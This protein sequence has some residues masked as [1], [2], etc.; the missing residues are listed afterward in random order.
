MSPPDPDTFSQAFASLR[1]SL[2]Y[3]AHSVLHSQDE[4]ED[5]LQDTAYLAWRAVM[6]NPHS[7]EIGSGWRAYV[8]VIAR[9]C[10]LKRLAMRNRYD[11]SLSL[12]A[13]QM[14]DEEVY[15]VADSVGVV[16]A[17]FAQA[18]LNID[19]VRLLGG[20]RREDR[21][22]LLDHFVLDLS[23]EEMAEAYDKADDTMRGRLFRAL[24]RAAIEAGVER[25]HD[26]GGSGW[27]PSV[28]Q[29]R[30]K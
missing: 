27:M 11:D 2:A 4:I 20:L 21:A 22:A 7:Y 14:I 9:N 25:R 23:Y 6:T 17:G 26:R 8:R 15:T 1:S 3:I 5:V 30:T 10:A 13:P 12:D 24:D 29:G 28:L 16:E 18:E 19:V